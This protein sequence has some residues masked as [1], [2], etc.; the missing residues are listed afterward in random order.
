MT[1]PQEE[2]QAPAAHPDPMAG[3]TLSQV[4]HYR[5]NLLPYLQD[6][7]TAVVAHV[8]HLVAELLLEDPDPRPRALPLEGTVMFADIDGFTPLAERF[9]EA[10]SEEGAEE[11]TELV[12]RFMQ[13]LIPITARYGGDLQKFGGDAGLLLFHGE[14]HALRAVAAALEVQA[15]MQAQM[16]ALQ[17]SLG[18]FSLRI[19]IGL[20]SGRM[21]GLGVGDSA[22]RDFLLI[23]DPLDAMGR[24]Q[25][26]APPDGTVVAAETLAACGDAV[27]HE[28]LGDDLHLITG[29]EGASPE[30]ETSARLTFPKIEPAA[31]LQWLLSRLDVLSPHLAPGLLE[32]LVTAP[33]PET[34]YL[35]SDLRQV[36]V[37]MLSLPAL[38]PLLAHWEDRAQ[39]QVQVEQVSAAFVQ[40]RDTIHRYDGIVNKIGISPKGPYLMALFGAPRAHEDDPLRALLAALELQEYFDGQLQFGINTGYVFA[41]DMGT[42][43]RREYTV[44]GDEVN[45]AYRMMAT[46]QP[47]EIWLG[48]TTYHHPAVR[49]RAEGRLGRGTRFKGK[50]DPITP[51][52]AKGVQRAAL[53]TVTESL[54]LVGR[55]EEFERLARALREVKQGQQ[56]IALI[57]GRAGVGKSRLVQEVSA[58]AKR[59]GFAVHSGTAPSYGAHLPFAAWDSALRS[60]WELNPQDELAEQQARFRLALERAD[61]GAWAALL[62]PLVGLEIPPSP[63]VLALPPEMRETRRQGALQSVWARAAAEQPRLLLLEN[64]QWL[65]PVSREL[66]EAV[67]NME[68]QAPLM[69]LATYREPLAEAE[70]WREHPGV[71]SFSLP[72]LT[73]TA[74]HILIQHL[75]EG[76]PL[77][78][79]VSAWVVARSGGLPLFATEAVQA[80]LE[81][82]LLQR[83]GDRWELRGSLADFPLPDMV[84]GLIQSRI[85][86]LAPPTRHLLR[87]AS[88][89][90]DQMTLALL[91]AAYGEESLPVVRRRLPQLQPFGLSPRDLSGE[92]LSFQQPLVREVAY[93]GLPQRVKRLIHQRLAEHLDFARERAMPN[94]RNQLAYHAFEGQLWSKA[95]EANLALG[96]RALQAYLA[97]QAVTAFSY[98]IEA[99][100]NGGLAAT[101]AR[102]E[103]HHRLGEALTTLG[104]YAEAFSHLE[105]ARALLPITPATPEEIAQ[106]AEIIY[107]KAVVFEAQGEYDHAAAAVEEGLALPDVQQALVGARLYLLGADLFRRKNDYL[108]AQQWAQ[109]SSA[110]CARFPG[111]E[112][113]QLR[114]RAM[115]MLALLASLRRLT[116]A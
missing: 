100:D 7:L 25:S 81:S 12:N 72:P 116:R 69:V 89:V 34:V 101:G 93:R 40:V 78:T 80:L 70:A 30:L 15:A 10:A 92:V 103:A 46:C 45:L 42:A 56:R 112:A 114:S 115:Y 71:L 48:P 96:N 16:R 8:P 76:A 22:G 98:V 6:L 35:W 79:E 62:A 102:F 73:A 90:G 66:L 68:T 91:A 19:A 54:P 108:Q 109:R 31:Q 50:R 41:G 82:G 49:N 37:M 104:Q 86:Q 65:S 5:P 97:N 94:W 18:E 59:M 51:F 24:A 53:L 107:R 106:L 64:V 28:S 21:V 32:R 20:G 61:L 83:S 77:P 63:E 9:S 11:L 29:L 43:A 75:F 84:Y 95:I 67:L 113:Q 39:L 55:D 58:L 27:A 111:P 85:D 23:G 26:A 2:H 4:L 110:L 99:A 13:L 60:L 47:G 1:H 14:G 44:M 87:A 105:A 57:H 52:I 3:V 74:I 17:T 38:P 36:T 33:D 88:V